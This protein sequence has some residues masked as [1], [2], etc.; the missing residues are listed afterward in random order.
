MKL[1][2][3]TALA[4]DSPGMARLHG[5]IQDRMHGLLGP[6][7][8]RELR[9]HI[10]IQNKVT[11]AEARALQLRLG[12]KLEHRAFRFAGFGLHAF[13]DGLWRPIKSFPFRG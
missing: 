12:P 10:T 1:A 2:Q 8:T 4:I 11:T 7:D 3:G 13:V 6:Q 9:L 5:I